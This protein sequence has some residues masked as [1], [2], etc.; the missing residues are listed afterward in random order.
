MSFLRYGFDIWLLVSCLHPHR[1][2]LI[3]W[4]LFISCCGSTSPYMLYISHLTEPWWLTGKLLKDVSSIYIAAVNSSMTWSFR[5]WMCRLPSSSGFHCWY[6]KALLRSSVGIET[7]WIRYRVTCWRIC[8]SLGNPE[9]LSR[10]V[11]YKC[12]AQGHLDHLFVEDEP[13]FWNQKEVHFT[14]IITFEVCDCVNVL[15]ESPGK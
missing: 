1:Y 4:L 3:H 8:V 10:T 5:R 15:Q 9:A 6:N 7:E 11:L 13:P 2:P 12:G 14:Q